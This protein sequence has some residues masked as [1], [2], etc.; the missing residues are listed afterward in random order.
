M[1]QIEKFYEEL[2]AGG[3]MKH[4]VDMVVVLTTDSGAEYVCCPQD[5]RDAFL[6]GAACRILK[7]RSEDPTVPPEGTIGVDKV[8][9][10]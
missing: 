5:T 7:L 6:T 1:T 2:N 9:P 3:R 4:V 10:K 8:E